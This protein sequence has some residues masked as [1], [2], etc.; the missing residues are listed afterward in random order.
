M[1]AQTDKAQKEKDLDYLGRLLY[2]F[3]ADNQRKEALAKLEADHSGI[4]AANIYLRMRDG[5]E[6]LWLTT[7][8][9]VEFR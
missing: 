1:F 5:E 7:A 6:F 8:A 2:P 3:N 4:T 9:R